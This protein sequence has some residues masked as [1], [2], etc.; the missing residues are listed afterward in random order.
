[1]KHLI[2]PTDLTKQETD[3]II[4]LAQDIIA[5]RQKYQEILAHKKFHD[6]IKQH[7]KLPYKKWWLEQKD[8]YVLAR[9]PELVKFDEEEYRAEQER[10]EAAHA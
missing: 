7:V 5:D 9:H 3:Q 2:D 10:K 8:A 1:M 4:A 6:D